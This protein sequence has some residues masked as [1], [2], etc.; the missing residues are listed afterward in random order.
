MS[1]RI[2]LCLAVLLALAP[3][4]AQTAPVPAAP[5][6]L[7]HFGFALVACGVDDPYD[8][9]PR[10]D[11]VREVS[12]FTDVLHV[13]AF[14]PTDAAHL[15][16]I[17]DQAEAL[18]VRAILDLQGIFFE[19]A[20]TGTAPSGGRPMVLR[21]DA[22]DRWRTLAKAADLTGRRDAL[23]ATLVADEPTWNGVS[24]ADL[25]AAMAEVEAALPDLPHMLVEAWPVVDRWSI[26]PETDWVGFDRYG[27]AD[28]NRDPALPGA[29][30]DP[31]G[32][33]DPPG[34]ARL[35]DLREPL[36]AG[37]RR[38]RV[39]PGDVGPHRPQL[40]RPGPPNPG[41]PGPGGL[42]VA[43]R[44]RVPRRVGSPQSAARG[45]TPLPPDRCRHPARRLGS[46]GLAAG[47]ASSG[48][49]H[50][51]PEPGVVVSPER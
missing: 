12:S 30:G 36:V 35:P 25:R 3:A 46:P 42:A 24:E 49:A 40:L 11:Y 39:H 23:A 51:R 27:V 43:R 22:A 31:P 2:F 32:A 19:R 9:I 45:A 20:A 47:S 6:H 16:A 28:P 7:R 34:S 1:H 41:G 48:D 13:C 26:P 8:L 17:L 21:A 33:S 14:E 18:G 38:G 37:L 44:L 29:P 15:A 5:D 50:A 4:A 10:P